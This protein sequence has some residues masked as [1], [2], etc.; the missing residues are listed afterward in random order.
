MMMR[1]LWF[2]WNEDEEDGLFWCSQIEPPCTIGEKV[3]FGSDE[4]LHQGTVQTVEN[5]MVGVRMD[6]E[7]FSQ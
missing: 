3:M 5:G 1:E 2:D 6:T 7:N 4:V